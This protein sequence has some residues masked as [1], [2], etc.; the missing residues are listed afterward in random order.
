MEPETIMGRFRRDLAELVT[1]N[2]DN[3]AGHLEELRAAILDWGR[4]V[5][6]NR[7]ETSQALKLLDE[8]AQAIE[9]C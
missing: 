1:T 8:V 4:D 3:L 7:R 2:P 6:F 5:R 9:R